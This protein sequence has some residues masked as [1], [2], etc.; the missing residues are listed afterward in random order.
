MDIII[1]VCFAVLA[2]V[3]GI[4]A[5]TRQFQML[6]QNSYFAVRYW[7]WYK[8]S[9]KLGRLVYIIISLL[10]AA[11]A[12]L[13]PTLDIVWRI[14]VSAVLVLFLFIVAK[15]STSQNKKSIK[16]LVVTARV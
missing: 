7:R 4:F 14:I 5:L 1:S 8:G 3:C 12:Y 2:A 9:F 10:G 11:G 15:R 13:A 16:K 6:Q